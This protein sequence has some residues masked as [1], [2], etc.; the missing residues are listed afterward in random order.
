MRPTHDF[1]SAPDFTA[2]FATARTHAAR[3]AAVAPQ[4]SQ[5]FAACASVAFTSS[6]SRAAVP[7][8]AAALG[9]AVAKTTTSASERTRRVRGP[10]T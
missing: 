8:R 10:K 7:H 2:R 1:A 3:R 9:L 6:A 5:I 4:Q